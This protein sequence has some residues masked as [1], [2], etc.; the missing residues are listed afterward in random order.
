MTPHAFVQPFAG[1]ASC[2]SCHPREYEHWQMSHHARAQERR[3]DAGREAAF[4]SDPGAREG[5]G[6]LVSA[7]GPDGT[8]RRY[9]V[10]A[11]IGV[12][13]LVQFLVP[14]DRGRLQPT[15][16]S[17]D[18][19]RGEWFDL[20]APE[21]RRPDE[22]GH[23]TGRGMTWNWA[24]AYCHVTG[25]QKGYDA[26]A[27]SYAS[28]WTEDGVGCES[29]HGARAAHATHPA[30]RA[31]V[32]QPFA[33]SRAI[34]ETCA[35]CHSRRG[36]IAEGFEP[37]LDGARVGQ[38]F[39][40]SFDPVLPGDPA[41]HA[42]GQILEEDYEWGSFLQS[43]MYANGVGCTDCHDP[44]TARTK[45]EGNALCL[46]CHRPEMQSP[47]HVRHTP[48]SPGALCVSCHMPQT[49]YMLRHARRDHSFTVPQPSLTVRYGIPNACNHCHPDRDAVWAAETVRRWYPSRPRP[50]AARAALMF[51]ARAGRT[52]AIPDLIAQLESGDAAVWRASAADALGRWTSE[53]A[54][55]A[56]LSRACVDTEPLVRAHAARSLAP[57]YAPS[58]RA[59][60][61]RLQSDPVRV[62]R[63]AAAG[64]LVSAELQSGG[65]PLAGPAM[66]ELEAAM[67][68]NSDTPSGRLALAQ[69]RAGRGD[70]AAAERE[71]RVGLGFDPY[72]VPLRLGL[73]A[74]LSDTG[75]YDE[76]RT[77]LDDGLR[78]APRD[79]T[80]WLARGI[81]DLQAGRRSEA[82][83]A[84]RQSAQLS[85]EGAEAR[86]LLRQLEETR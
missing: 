81:A 51:E 4:T 75:R 17:W 50:A 22:W 49:T 78:L 61:E 48:A 19:T 60:L 52:S 54:A 59:R 26:D 11:A 83:R 39:L 2:A 12:A 35:P 3:I 74:R 18:P 14:F 31:T 47:A 66:A 20:H 24:C 43:R 34:V 76:T 7:Q 46:R 27:D 44:H 33:S 16:A 63:L 40:D 36:Q 70:A 56:A 5:G 45:A 29:C 82:L 71:Y 69:Y 15:A 28:R 64:A 67:I 72:A 73:A 86:Q 1:S 53:P 77:T 13:P 65:R 25:F 42:D 9:P 80:L 85:P 79:P 21:R 41:Y 10:V 8:R 55:R 84:L 32:A 23:W 38:T 62:V 68:L 37:H 58:E 6:F 57:P 30:S